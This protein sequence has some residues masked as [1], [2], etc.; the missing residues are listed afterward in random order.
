MRQFLSKCI[1][2][3]LPIILIILLPTILYLK[4]DPYSDFGRKK[5]YSW[6]YNFQSLGDISTKKLLHSSINYNSFIFGSSR[7][8]G[9]FGCYLQKKIPNS[10]FFHYGN[11]NET[12]GGI[13]QKIKLI[14][15]LGYKID[16]A[17][18]YIDTDYTFEDEGKCNS[19]DHYLLTKESRKQY[20]LNHY[21]SYFSSFNIDRLKI[22]LGKQV[23]G[24]I[25]PNWESDL[26]TNDPDHICTDSI[27]THYGD[28]IENIEYLYTIDSL[29]QS[30]FFYNRP[31]SQ[32]YKAKQISDF[33]SKYLSDIMQIFS[34]H[35][36]SYY[37]IITP[38][39]D[40]L[41]FESSDMTTIYQYLGKSVY[42]F[43]GNS[44]IT[45]KISNYPDGKH[46]QKYISK[47]ILDSIIN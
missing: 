2:F 44:E 4:R 10:K 46:F 3:L 14:D 8:A 5:N 33:E 20:I 24:D 30:G 25:F 36:T 32:T 9:V 12:I 23:G 13:Y 42:D 43:S 28:I 11:W 26:A 27:V 19:F 39:Y 21:R 6:K 34:K 17:I 35:H 15:S 18:I 22:L 41:K 37:V 1:Y 7:S 29:K 47:I 40:E 38:L 16:N 45:Q 31:E